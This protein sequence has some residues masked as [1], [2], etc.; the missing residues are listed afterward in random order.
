MIRLCFADIHLR[1]C[2][3][4][5]TFFHVYIIDVSALCVCAWEEGGFAHARRV[6]RAF[7]RAH[8]LC[9]HTAHEQRHGE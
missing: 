5:C 8:Q 2:I 3:L 9:L 6:T 4:R 1:E 7:A